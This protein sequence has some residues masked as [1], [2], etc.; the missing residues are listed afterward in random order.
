LKVSLWPVKQARSCWWARRATTSAAFRE[1]PERQVWKTVR[2]FTVR[3]VMWIGLGVTRI[4]AMRA[5]VRGCVRFARVMNQSAEYSRSYRK[6]YGFLHRAMVNIYNRLW[7]H[8]S[9]EKWA[10]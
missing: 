5:C 3:S 10:Y 1:I 4:G 8:E 6:T 2:I 7:I 9:Q